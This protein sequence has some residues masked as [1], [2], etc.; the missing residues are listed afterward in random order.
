MSTSRYAILAAISIS[1]IAGTLPV[2]AQTN[3]VANPA[4]VYAVLSLIGDRL[5][6]VT[7]QIQSGIRVDH[8]RRETVPLSDP[9]FD[10]SAIAAAAREITKRNSRAEVAALNTRS[11]VLFEKHRELFAPNDGVLSIPEAIK[12]AIAAQKATHFILITRYNDEAVLKYKDGHDGA[13]RLEGLGFY[14]D[15][16]NGRGVIVPYAYL[17]LVLVDV[18]TQRV[19]NTRLI[20]ASIAMRERA[21]MPNAGS[22]AWT[23]LTSAEKVQVIDQLIRDEITQVIPD[24]LQGR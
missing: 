4:P 6:I 8:S 5:E 21:A 16:I 7:A 13:D 9:L 20:R 12:N 14:L 2:A 15:A 17:K 1:L 19:L 18:A 3:A 22:P 24:L 23:T 10:N 11:A